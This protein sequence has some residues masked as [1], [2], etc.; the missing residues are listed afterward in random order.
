MTRKLLIYKHQ[1][2]FST[3]FP[4]LFTYYKYLAFL[5]IASRGKE[6]YVI[7]VSLQ[8]VFTVSSNTIL[9]L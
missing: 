3:L 9:G 2:N 7:R 1:V 4:Q 6:V 5:S 8:I